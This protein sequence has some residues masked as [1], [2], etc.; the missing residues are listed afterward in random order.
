VT[1]DQAEVVQLRSM[2]AVFEAHARSAGLELAGWHDRRWIKN[3]FDD[4]VAVFRLAP[5]KM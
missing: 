4:V 2:R 1:K 3:Q 5:A